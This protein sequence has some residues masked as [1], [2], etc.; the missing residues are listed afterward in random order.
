MERGPVV[1][2]LGPVGRGYLY[3]GGIL[4]GPAGEARL[5]ASPVDPHPGNEP[6]FVE[7]S[8]TLGKRQVARL[9]DLDRSIADCAQWRFKV[10]GPAP[11]SFPEYVIEQGSGT[12]TEDDLLAIRRVASRICWKSSD[13]VYDTARAITIVP[14]RV[15]GE[16]QPAATDPGRSVA[17]RHQQQR[18]RL[19]TNGYQV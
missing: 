8:V 12:L 7:L 6:G 9:N 19:D 5:A 17:P 3:V 15:A 10:A 1:W 13:G 4:I 2:S 14:Y 16:R 18:C 11:W